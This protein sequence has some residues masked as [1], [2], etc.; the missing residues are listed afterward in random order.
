[1]LTLWR[2]LDAP[3][4]H[5]EAMAWA[6]ALAQFHLSEARRLVDAGVISEEV[7]RAETLRRWLVEEWRETVI[8][9]SEILQ[10]GPNSLRDS[11][12]MRAALDMLVKHRWVEP[13]QKG[14]HVRGRARKEAYRIVRPA[15]VG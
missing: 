2:D 9:P 15:D 12:R 14:I 7:K 6:L 11:K 13:L 4:V 10:R 1:M 8:T 5:L 3:E